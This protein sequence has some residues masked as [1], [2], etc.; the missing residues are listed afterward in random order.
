M[1]LLVLYVI[2]LFSLNALINSEINESL[3]ERRCIRI[4]RSLDIPSDQ[5]AVYGIGH[6]P[7]YDDLESD[8]R[9]IKTL[10][11]IMAMC[12]IVILTLCCGCLQYL[13]ILN[14]V[15]LVIGSAFNLARQNEFE[16]NIQQDGGVRLNPEED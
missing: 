1:Y 14:R 11:L 7:A 4:P 6:P 8:I 3:Q 15:F 2:G 16:M 5:Q 10:C 9:I 13:G 12:L